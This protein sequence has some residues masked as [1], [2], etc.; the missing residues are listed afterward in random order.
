MFWV[1]CVGPQVKHTASL[2]LCN[3]RLNTSVK[4]AF[5]L[6]GSFIIFSISYNLEALGKFENKEEKSLIAIYNSTSRVVIVIVAEEG[7][8]DVTRG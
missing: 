8:C 4:F 5:S 7:V 6:L 3:I 2:L 1:L